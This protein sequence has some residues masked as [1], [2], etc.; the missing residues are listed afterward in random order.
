MISAVSCKIMRKKVVITGASGYLGQH[1]L[2]YLSENED[3]GAN[4]MDIIAVYGNL[5]SFSKSEFG[6]NGRNKLLAKLSL[7][8]TD[9]EE[10]R[11]FIVKERPNVLV[12]LAAI[13]SPVICAKDPDQAMAVNCPYHLVQ[14]C[15]EVGVF[16]I[17]L[18]TDHVY[19]GSR[20]TYQPFYVE[21]DSTYPLN[22]YGKSKLAFE[23]MLQCHIPNQSV[24]LR[25][26]I[27][28]GPPTKNECRKQT[29]LQFVYDRLKNKQR[30]DFFYDEWRNFIFVKDVCKIICWFLR[31][32]P[33]KDHCS[34]YNMGGID[35]VSRD[36]FAK[37]MARVAF[38]EWSQSFIDTLVIPVSKASIG[39]Q[40]VESPSNIAMDSGKLRSVCKVQTATLDEMIRESL[41]EI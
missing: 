18:S 20:Q 38:P 31:E 35:R 10:V 21:T 14:V 23:Q 17:F 25:S 30:T 9:S 27:I 15:K 37:A 11:R 13:S 33:N 5:E 1:L 22:T 7:D 40:L 3:D 4:G 24:C 8:F 2:S 6:F 12:H 41:F 26:S 39:P 19:D 32:N 36:E 34:V 28:L 29:F 16:I